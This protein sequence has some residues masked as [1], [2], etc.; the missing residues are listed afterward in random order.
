MANLQRTE[1]ANVKFANLEG[2]LYAVEVYVPAEIR[3]FAPCLGST[4]SCTRVHCRAPSTMC[5][6][7]R[8]LQLSSHSCLSEASIT[9]ITTSAPYWKHPVNFLAHVHSTHPGTQ[10]IHRSKIWS[11][12]A[13]SA[14]TLLIIFTSLTACAYRRG[15]TSDITLLTVSPSDRRHSALTC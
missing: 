7:S 13:R 2:Q 12:R 6:I 9:L 14:W 4:K 8:Y 1:T 5:C 10:K 15:P 11:A 3:F